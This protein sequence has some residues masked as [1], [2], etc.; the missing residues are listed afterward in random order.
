MEKISALFNQ[1]GFDLDSQYVSVCNGP[2]V[3]EKTKETRF[4]IQSCWNDKGFATES[5]QTLVSTSG[6]SLR[7][8]QQ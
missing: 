2:A 1:Q 6:C 3:M 5:L 4:I 8:I 7:I